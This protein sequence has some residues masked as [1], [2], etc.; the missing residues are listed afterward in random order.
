[1]IV[2]NW[3]MNMTSAQANEF[4]DEYAKHIKKTKNKVV[5]C[6]PF[7]TMPTVFKRR[8]LGF[9]LGAQ[10]V[11]PAE[12]GTHTGEISAKMLVD[13][14]VTSVI[15]G[16]SERRAQF[17]E[18]NSFINAKIKAAVAA[19]LQVIFCIGETADEREMGKTFEVLKKQFIEGMADIG[20]EAKKN[21]VIAYEPVWAISGGDP[22]KPSPT[23]KSAEIAE[24][25]AFIRKLGKKQLKSSRIPILYGG[26]ANDKNFKEIFVIENVDGALVGGASL[27]PSKFAAM[28]NFNK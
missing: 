26:S 24:V 12:N 20:A 23:P 28:C 6:A 25:H 16:H 15:I 7:T 10:N 19:G 13:A 1:M 4:F 8:R 22:N 11:H 2:A 17:G 9:K 27:V 3:K 21:I 14:K 5:I 18:C